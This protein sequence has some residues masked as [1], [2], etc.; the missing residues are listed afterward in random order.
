M[1]EEFEVKEYLVKTPFLGLRAGQFTQYR[2]DEAQKY[3]DLGCLEEIVS[4][5]KAKDPK[6]PKAEL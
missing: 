2:T 5:P 3:I 6:T 1:N 4:A